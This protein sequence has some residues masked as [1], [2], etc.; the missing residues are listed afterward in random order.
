MTQLTLVGGGVA[1][2]A[3]E[4][5]ASQLT[6]WDQGRALVDELGRLSEKLGRS[7]EAV[8]HLGGSHEPAIAAADG[9]VLSEECT[10]SSSGG[11]PAFRSS[12][13]A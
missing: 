3:S 13:D 12:D 8:M 11:R 5:V 9:V 2:P 4:R 1:T 6:P 10:P 7:R